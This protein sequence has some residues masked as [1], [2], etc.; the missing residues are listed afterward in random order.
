MKRS[1]AVVVLALCPSLA[2]AQSGPLTESLPTEEPKTLHFRLGPLVISPNVV[3]R[4]FGYD[5]NVFNEDVNPKQ[6]WTVTMSPDLKYF[7]RLGLLQFSGA[8]SSDFTYYHQYE[9]ERSIARQLR[10]RLD[11]YLS[12]FRPW[13]S[14][15]LVDLN[16]RPNRE[17]D[18]R[19]RR[20]DDEVSAGLMFSLSPVA[21]IYGMGTRLHSEYGSEEV[22]EGVNL[23]QALRRRSD[24]ISAGIK[25]QP[26]PFTTVLLSG[27]VNEDDFVDSPIRNTRSQSVDAQFTFS[28][29][30]VI[31]GRLAVGYEDMTP[32]DPAVEPFRGFTTSGT[33]TYTL[34]GRATIDT[35]VLRDVTYSF[36]TSE[37]Y[38]VETGLDV[39]YT[40]LL[41]GPFD[42]QF[43]ASRRWLD[44]VNRDGSSPAVDT[45]RAG[46]GYNFQ[47][48]SRV[49]VTFEYA[50]RLDDDQPDRRFH[51]RRFFA[52]YTYELQR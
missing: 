16:D 26:T 27:T 50:Q 21:A 42:A 17:I 41:T 30:A 33:I 48:R 9:S 43:F 38:Y 24:N 8:T 6:D 23:D 39:N 31:R 13:I 22:F 44:Y 19:A 18:T 28:P 3:V 11:W 15:A 4:D 14:G 51:R 34:L 29:E 46:V 52:S 25:L 7:A 47:D 1:L 12:R 5:T 40:Q 36:D 45:F 37:A 35:T 32:D 49:G 20:T 10:G 2:A